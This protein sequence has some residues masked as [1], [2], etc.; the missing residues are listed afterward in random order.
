MQILD[1]PCN[2]VNKYIVLSEANFHTWRWRHIV[3]VDM[4][5]HNF[6]CNKYL[7]SH[8]HRQH[9]IQVLLQL[10]KFSIVTIYTICY[11]L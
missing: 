5:Q 1:F 9:N 7:S 4:R 10:Q 6:L 3:K 8:N 11:N 2:L